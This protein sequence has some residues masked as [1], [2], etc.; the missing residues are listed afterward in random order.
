MVEGILFLLNKVISGV[1]DLYEMSIIVI[2]F[3]NE[4]LTYNY[5][6]RLFYKLNF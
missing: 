3:W 1:K 6:Y 4:S 5:E 2:L